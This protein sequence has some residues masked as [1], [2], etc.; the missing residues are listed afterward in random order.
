MCLQEGAII[1]LGGKSGEVWEFS[2]VTTGESR[3]SKEWAGH[4]AQFRLATHSLEQAQFIVRARLE[5]CEGDQE[6]S[7]I[8]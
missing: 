6:I 3:S 2:K 5:Q 8:V 1:L 7:S 4:P